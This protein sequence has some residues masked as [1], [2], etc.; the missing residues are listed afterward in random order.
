MERGLQGNRNPQGDF[1]KEE[2]NEVDVTD[3]LAIKN[4]IMKGRVSPATDE[5]K[6]KIAKFINAFREKNPEGGRDVIYKMLELNPNII[7]H[8]TP[9]QIETGTFPVQGSK[10]FQDDMFGAYNAALEMVT[11]KLRDED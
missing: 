10:E 1:I 8:L 9:E 5:T 2:S 7:N 4:S 3:M 11:S 6:T